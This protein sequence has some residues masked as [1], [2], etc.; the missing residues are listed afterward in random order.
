MAAEVFETIAKAEE[1]QE[2]Q[3]LP[4]IIPTEDPGPRFVEAPVV[5]KQ[6]EPFKVEVKKPKRHP[7]NTPRFSRTTK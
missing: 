2:E 4:E 6:R 1:K 7:R 5:E 3:I